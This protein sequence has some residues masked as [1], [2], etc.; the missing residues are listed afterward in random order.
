LIDVGRADAIIA[1]TIAFAIIF[2]TLLPLM[3]LPIRYFRQMP[4]M[5]PLIIEY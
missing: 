2:A 1:I 4:L 3:P 5:L